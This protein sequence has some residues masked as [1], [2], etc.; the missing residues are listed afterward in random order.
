MLF[1]LNFDIPSFAQDNDYKVYLDDLYCSYQLEYGI[2]NG[3]ARCSRG[4]GGL[5]YEIPYKNDQ[6]EG[7]ERGYYTRRLTLNNS[8]F[9]ISI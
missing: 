7:V 8:E 4:Y 2:K 3:V 6:K 5:Q 1:I 9:I